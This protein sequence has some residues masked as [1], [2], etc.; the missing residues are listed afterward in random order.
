M[1]IQKGANVNDMYHVNVER[2][3]AETQQAKVKAVET[4]IKPAW[5]LKKKQHEVVH[6]NYEYSLF[7][8]STIS[9]PHL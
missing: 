2:N 7:Q 6:K 8:A 4:K 5:T 9:I 3:E 1:L